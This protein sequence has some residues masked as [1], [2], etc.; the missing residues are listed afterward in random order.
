WK[1][2]SQGWNQKGKQPQRKPYSRPSGNNRDH[3]PYRP[4]A[5]AY[6]GGQVRNQP[7]DNV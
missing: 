6:G 1:H 5:S 7:Q 4:I 2:S 3:Q